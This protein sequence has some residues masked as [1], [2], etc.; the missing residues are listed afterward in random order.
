MTQPEKLRH[1]PKRSDAT[2]AVV[3]TAFADLR[4]RNVTACVIYALKA[5]GSLNQKRE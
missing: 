1:N 2:I 4:R 5:L 3:T